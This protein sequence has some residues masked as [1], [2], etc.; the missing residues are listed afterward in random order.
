VARKWPANSPIP[1]KYFISFSATQVAYQYYL[2]ISPADGH[3]YISDP[4]KHQIL[5]VL[6]LEQVQDPSINIEPVV[7]SGERCIPGDEGHCGDEGPAIKAKLAHPKGKERIQTYQSS[8]R[9]AF[10]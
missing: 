10:A 7:G 1:L 8:T 4:E 5:K 3:L 9:R 6:S 2:C